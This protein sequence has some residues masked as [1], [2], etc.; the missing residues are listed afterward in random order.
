[1]MKW[2]KI[3]NKD[4][5]VYIVNALQTFFQLFQSGICRKTITRLKTWIP[6]HKS[7][8]VVLRSGRLTQFKSFGL[9]LCKSLLKTWKLDVARSKAAATL[10]RVVQ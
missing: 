4:A 9:I 7:L 3:P 6:K 2:W 5:E 8:P 10:Q 1:M